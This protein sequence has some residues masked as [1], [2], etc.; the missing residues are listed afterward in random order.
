[1]GAAREMA[2]YGKA[3]VDHLIYAVFNDR[4]FGVRSAAVNSLGTI[5]DKSVCANLRQLANNNPYEKTIM[6]PEE[7][8]QFVAYEDFRKVLRAALAKIGC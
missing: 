7:Q 2:K 4:D 1:A 3:A 5:G 6:T 8:K